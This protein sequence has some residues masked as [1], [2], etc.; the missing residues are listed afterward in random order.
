MGRLVLPAALHAELL[1][2][3][4]LM[5]RLK[6][7]FSRE[8]K[9]LA[10]SMRGWRDLVAVWSRSAEKGGFDVRTLARIH[11]GLETVQTHLDLA[12][13]AFSRYYTAHNTRAIYWLTIAILIFTL[14]QVAASLKLW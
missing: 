6:A 4:I 11:F 14:V 10:G 12:H 1:R 7:E 8:E 5:N 9:W 3:S 13:E 2:Q